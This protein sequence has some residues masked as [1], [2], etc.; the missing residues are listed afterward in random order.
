MIEA[1]RGVEAH[2]V[3]GHVTLGVIGC[4]RGVEAHGPIGRASD[5][6]DLEARD[7]RPGI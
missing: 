5:W 3:P 2:D 6:P 4:F 7:L 1:Q